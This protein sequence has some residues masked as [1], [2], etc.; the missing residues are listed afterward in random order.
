M[1]SQIKLQ[2]TLLVGTIDTDVYHEMTML[3]D[4]G[5]LLHYRGNNEL[6]GNSWRSYF[7]KCQI[8][9]ESSHSEK[10]LFQTHVDVT[11]F[12]VWCAELAPSP[13]LKYNINYTS[14][15]RTWS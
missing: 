8:G 9:R 1:Q 2:L 6:T 3:Y 11:S 10:R 14:H 4:L 12:V 15:S 7:F 5:K 13:K